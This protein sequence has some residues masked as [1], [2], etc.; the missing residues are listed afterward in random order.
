MI[1]FKQWI[2]IIVLM[3]YYFYYLYFKKKKKIIYMMNF[4]YVI[5]FNVDRYKIIKVDEVIIRRE[6]N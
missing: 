3:N 6:K 5:Y 2:E 1:R 4:F